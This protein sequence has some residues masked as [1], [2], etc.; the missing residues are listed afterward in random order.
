MTCLE[1]NRS[2]L[3][4]FIDIEDEVRGAPFLVL[5]LLHL[6]SE[7]IGSKKESEMFTNIL[8]CIPQGS[9]LNP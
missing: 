3:Y 5:F 8:A 9:S 6:R 1:V 7:A 2:Q 4:Q